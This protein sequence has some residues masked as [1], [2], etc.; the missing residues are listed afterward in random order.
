MPDPNRMLNLSHDG[1]VPPAEA[2]ASRW[3]PGA[4]ARLVRGAD[5]ALLEAR[6]RE[7]VAVLGRS[8]SRQSPADALERLVRCVARYR[9]LAAAF[10]RAALSR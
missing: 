8:R 1:P 10:R 7:C 9:S 3:G 4:W 2:A 6:L 5:A